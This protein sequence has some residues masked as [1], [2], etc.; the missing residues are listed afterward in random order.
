MA[1]QAFS[2]AEQVLAV[3]FEPPATGAGGSMLS[4]TSTVTE[5][6]GTPSRS[7]ASCASTV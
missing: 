3:V 1:L 6:S 2:T 5:E 7:A 4:P